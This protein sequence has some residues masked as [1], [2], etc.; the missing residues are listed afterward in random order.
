MDKLLTFEPISSWPHG[1]QQQHH[2]NNVERIIRLGI[3]SLFLLLHILSK[4]E[5]SPLPL[6]SSAWNQPGIVINAINPSHEAKK[7]MMGPNNNNNAHAATSG[8]E[9]SSSSASGVGARRQNQL[10]SHSNGQA[11]TKKKTYTWNTIMHYGLS[12]GS[13]HNIR[14]K[15][16]KIRDHSNI[17]CPFDQTRSWWDGKCRP[18]PKFSLYRVG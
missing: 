14:H 2:T 16:K 7:S 11:E 10:Y 4:T 9:K 3:I 8:R 5:A 6:P 17:P 12:G 15:A 13:D 1:Q 18:A